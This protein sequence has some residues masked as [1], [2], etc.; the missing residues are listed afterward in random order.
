MIL[1]EQVIK[2]VVGPG[3][4]AIARTLKWGQMADVWMQPQSIE[5][6][7]RWQSGARGNS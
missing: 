2:P 6:R 4:V 1:L 5:G 7:P 3:H